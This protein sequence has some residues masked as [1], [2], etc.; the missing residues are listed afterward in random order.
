MKNRLAVVSSFNPSTTLLSTVTKL[1][2]YYSEFDIVIV[3]SDSEDFSVYGLLPPKC[4][5][6]YVKNKNYELGAW[7]YAFKTYP[8][9]DVY[10]FIQDTLTPNCRIPHFDKNEYDNG[11]IYTFHFHQPLNAFGFFN[12]SA[13]VYRDSNLHFIS[14]LDPSMPITGGA[15]TSFI[16]NKEHVP[17]ILQLEDAYIHKNVKKTKIDSLLSERTLG[18]MAD[19]LP[20]RINIWDYFTKTH[21]NRI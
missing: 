18:I 17:T 2:E 20:K 4:K 14:K 11:T 10:M 13:D 1:Q 5:V 9:Y 21:G 8:N 6:D 3:D 16:T 15:H 19:T 7:T 12:E